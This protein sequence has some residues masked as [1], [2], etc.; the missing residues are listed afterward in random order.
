M[1]TPAIDCN[2]APGSPLTVVLLHP[3]PAMGG[4]RFNHVVDALF[5]ALPPQG[6]STA[7]FDFGS[8]DVMAAAAEADAV[9]EQCATEVAVI[10]YSFGAG[11]ALN[12]SGAPVVGWLL[13]APYLPPGAVGIARDERPKRVLVAEHDQ[14]CPPERALP[15]T[16]A[17]A[18]IDVAV[19]AG[20]DHFLA[21]ATGAIL[22]LAVEW[23]RRVAT[24][25]T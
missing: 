25:T 5:H 15:A 20:A 10:G 16:A 14:W 9:V 6:F 18:N 19:L 13:V 8:S 12:V 7:R 4:D 1:G 22:D 3:H 24:R 2:D 21:G 23:L 17:W 11:V